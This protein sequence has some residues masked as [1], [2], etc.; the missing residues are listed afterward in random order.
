MML[1]GLNVPPWRIA[2]AKMA[3]VGWVRH[4]F[5]WKEIEPQRGKPE[6]KPTVRAMGDL[7]AANLH[8]LGL[9][10]TAPVWAG[11][12]ETGATISDL[13]AFGN[14][15]E[16]VA[17]HAPMVAAWELWN[18]PDLRPQ[19]YGIGLEPKAR[20]ADLISAGINGL[21][22]GGTTAPIAAG[23]C[24]TRPG[25]KTLEVY[26]ALE[27]FARDGRIDFLSFH[28]NGGTAGADRVA[29]RIR[30][31]LAQIESVGSHLAKLP[32]WVTECGFVGG[33]RQM[34]ETPSVL[35]SFALRS[36][37][38]KAAFVYVDQDETAEDGAGIFDH[39]ARAKPI[40]SE[41]A[42]IIRTGDFLA[43]HPRSI[44]PGWREALWAR[45]L[46]RLRTSS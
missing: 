31:H 21:R 34:A 19:A 28:A 39:A 5:V 42:G 38:V 35:A 11:G 8:V 40:V 45:T 13:E 22:R 10:S 37:R 17:R 16:S 25:P 7:L 1:Y 23:V 14:F 6:W 15:C 36:T 2:N 20:Y 24:S 32:I 26:R 3:G 43:G 18:E 41:L 44:E 9:L 12:G 27:T 4:T 29:M 33:A 30:R 46:G